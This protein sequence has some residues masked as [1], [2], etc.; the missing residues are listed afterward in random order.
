MDTLITAIGAGLY[1]PPSPSRDMY[2]VTRTAMVKTETSVNGQS[3][4]EF[5]RWKYTVAFGYKY[6]DDDDFKALSDAVTGSTSGTYFS[7]YMRYWDPITQAYRTGYFISPTI[8]AQMYNP[9]PDAGYQGVQIEMT[10]G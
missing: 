4:G 7:I 2:N 6:L 3:L 9:P 5:V 1:E 10:E 8:T